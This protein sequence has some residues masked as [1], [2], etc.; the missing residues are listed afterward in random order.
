MEEY[1]IIGPLVSAGMTCVLVASN[2]GMAVLN[3]LKFFHLRFQKQNI[4]VDPEAERNGEART[5]R[6]GYVKCNFLL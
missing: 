6:P 5:R 3:R 2:C 1:K 4:E